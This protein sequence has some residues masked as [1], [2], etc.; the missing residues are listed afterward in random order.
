MVLPCDAATDLLDVTLRDESICVV[1][2]P[3]GEVLELSPSPEKDKGRFKSRL[4]VPK[5]TKIAYQKL[6][7]RQRPK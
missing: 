1:T 5:G 6:T 2:M 7:E 4:R 3:C